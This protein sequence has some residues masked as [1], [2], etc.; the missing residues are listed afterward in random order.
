MIN[1]PT[2]LVLGAVCLVGILLVQLSPWEHKAVRIS[3]RVVYMLLLVAVT[4]LVPLSLLLSSSL[5]AYGSEYWAMVVIS[6][7]VI[8]QTVYLSLY[9][10][11]VVASLKGKKWDIV[12]VRVLSVLECI[13]AVVVGVMAFQHDYVSMSIK[14]DY[15]NLFYV[16]CTA[17]SMA[18]TFIVHPVH[19][20]FKKKPAAAETAAAEE[21]EEAVP[22]LAQETIQETVQE[23]ESAPAKPVFRDLGDEMPLPPV[24]PKRLKKRRTQEAE[25]EPAQETAQKTEEKA[26][27]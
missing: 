11:L 24:K 14:N 19:L 10:L 5:Q 22:E 1:L 23:E 16:L 6:M 8:L 25:Q 12:C 2:L 15:F 13:A 7:V 3:L 18:L 9:P 20:P 27:V 21:A 4:A 17:A 26:G